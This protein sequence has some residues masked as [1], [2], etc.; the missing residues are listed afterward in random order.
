MRSDTA[1]TRGGTAALPHGVEP[2]PAREVDLDE[3]SGSVAAKAGC[4]YPGRGPSAVPPVAG[5]GL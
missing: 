4:L 5:E 1:F 2:V 3:G